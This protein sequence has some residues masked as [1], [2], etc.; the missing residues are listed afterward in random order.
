M[1]V[2]LEV[3]QA[4]PIQINAILPKIRKALKEILNLTYEPEVVA[5]SIWKPN[6]D[7]GSQESGLF[8][9]GVVEGFDVVIKGEEVIVAVFS[10]EEIDYFTVHPRGWRAAALG[11]AVA[12]AIAEHSESEVC[13]AQGTY[14]LKEYMKPNEFAQSIKVDKVF[15]DINEASEYF[16]YRLPGAVK[17]ESEGSADNGSL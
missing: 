9:P 3:E 16:F 14:S 6:Q 10:R 15:D 1:S 8:T 5:D 7:A 11:A 17:R 12:I 2:S 13:D 4:R